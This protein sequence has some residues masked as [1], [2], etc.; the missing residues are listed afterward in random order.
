MAVIDVSRHLLVRPTV[1]QR[2]LDHAGA[3]APEHTRAGIALAVAWA[4][5][6]VV[7]G[8]HAIAERS[9][10]AVVVIL[11]VLA[12]LRVAWT[13]AGP[14]RTRGPRPWSKRSTC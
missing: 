1:A 3:P 6:A 4:G 2:R 5:L 8:V 13:A 12:I 14:R 10:G 7:F 11:G 9:V